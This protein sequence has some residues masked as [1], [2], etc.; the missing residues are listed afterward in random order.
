MLRNISFNVKS[1][2]KYHKYFQN[3]GTVITIVSDV[4]YCAEMTFL[5]EANFNVQ[6]LWIV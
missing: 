1:K 3:Q 6:F 4:T 2:K 5:Q